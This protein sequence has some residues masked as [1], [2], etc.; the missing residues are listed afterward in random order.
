[1]NEEK[2]PSQSPPPTAEE[3]RRTAGVGLRSISR[4][5]TSK[6]RSRLTGLNPAATGIFVVFIV[7]YCL[8]FVLPSPALAVSPGKNGF[9]FLKIPD[10]A[11]F[12]AMHGASASSE[13]QDCWKANPA[14]LAFHPERILSFSQNAWYMNT[15][16]NTAAVNAGGFAFLWKNYNF[17]DTA[18]GSSGENLGDFT[19]RYGVISFSY[20]FKLKRYTGLGVS[21]KK[22]KQKIYGENYDHSAY[23]MGFITQPG[24]LDSVGFVISNLGSKRKFENAKETLP[25]QYLLG[26]LKKMG[27]FY[28]ASE[29]KYIPAEKI[30]YLLGLEFKRDKKITLRFASEYQEDFNL[31][32]GL[33][34]RDGRYFVDFAFLPHGTLEYAYITTAGFRF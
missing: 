25:R 26:S 34:F 11:R 18:R 7:V 15:Y 19:D 2:S 17:E 13:G 24:I 16:M 6:I 23:D 4:R 31:S 3:V 9:S 32:F 21:Y 22:I 14:A 8:Q 12:S 33:G 10:S 28:L 29:I 5:M 27:R 1:M 20:G 30:T